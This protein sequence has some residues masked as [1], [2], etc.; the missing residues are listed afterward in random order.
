M[1]LHIAAL[2]TQDAYGR[3]MRVNEANGARAS[4]LFVGRTREGTQWCVRDDVTDPELLREVRSLVAGEPRGEPA[5]D[6]VP[7][8]APYESVLARQS[9]IERVDRG[10]AYICQPT[11]VPDPRA[12]RV[13]EANA[14]ILQRYLSAWSGDVA[15]AQPMF[16]IAINGDAVAL[17]ASVR[18]TPEAHEAGVETT[19]SYRGQGHAGAVVSAW[20]TAVRE[21]GAEPLYSTS[22][23]NTASQ[24]VARKLGLRLFGSDYQIA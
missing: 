12:V 7:S 11:I 20:A 8:P 17:C 2:F 10:P 14:A 13:T 21:T 19:P 24:A 3:M 18:I 22:W 1:R 6:P 5:L 9:P 23:S 16:A 4:R 15:T